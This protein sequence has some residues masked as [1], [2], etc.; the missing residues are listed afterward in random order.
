VSA[1]FRIRLTI[2]LIKVVQPRIAL[3]L[4]PHTER[5]RTNGPHQARPE[6]L[7]PEVFGPD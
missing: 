2:F 4:W 1:E 6:I 5:E 3:Y 7:T